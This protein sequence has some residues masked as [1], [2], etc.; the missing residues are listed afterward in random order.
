MENIIINGKMERQKRKIIQAV[1]VLSLATIM[2]RIVGLFREMASAYF[3]G[4]TLVYD[5]FLLAF[6]IPNFFRGLLAE[7]GLNS[8]FIP[9]FADY[10]F[11]ERKEEAK[12][13]VSDTIGASLFLTLSVSLF[14]FI[15]S[16]AVGFCSLSDKVR[17]IFSFLR[18]T[19]FYL[20]FISFSALLG[21]VLN[22]LNHFSS[23][24]LSP[25]GLD[26]FWILSLFF[27]SPFFGSN[28]ERRTYSL[29][30]GL[31]LG[32]AAQ[33]LIPVPAF[34]RRGFSLKPTFNLKNPG[35]IRIG[36]LLL[37][38]IIGVAVT[39]INLLVDYLLAS[40][41][42]PGMVSSLWYAN[43]LMQLPLG[44]FGVAL[45]TVA[46]PS[47]SRFASLGKWE[48]M[49]ETLHFSL[50]LTF[51]LVIPAS[52]G[53][54]F[55]G[56]PIIR[57]LF[58][59]G[60]FTSQSTQATGRALLFY[61]LGLF[62]YAGSIVL[63]RAFY[64]L[65]DTRTPVKIGVISIFVNLILDLVLMVPLKQ[66]G[67][68]FATSLVGMGNFCLLFFLLRRK[69]G[70]LGGKRLL[71]SGLKALFLSSLAILLA[72]VYYHSLSLRMNTLWALLISFVMAGIFYFGINFLRYSQPTSLPRLSP[73]K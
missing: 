58:Q 55:F 10:L 42:A 17:L 23:P 19:I 40:V 39:P 43:R 52:L 38:L 2:V 1:G 51:L 66:G 72:F 62:A 9:V 59:R 7:G 6:M 63:T 71:K 27:L 48:E 14:F 68:A 26:F 29:I 5:A 56:E 21:G 20:V 25:L 46:L 37:P 30:I 18:F 15:I 36:K 44:I 41:I 11:P 65:R 57:V 8:A 45:G 61:S 13:L 16:S 67:I 12:K 31:I 54:I 34:L 64:A 69:I 4:T 49:K 22:S 50:S 24:A 33:F 32:G 73:D 53:L 35:L 28:L 70:L 47:M 3:F 60:L